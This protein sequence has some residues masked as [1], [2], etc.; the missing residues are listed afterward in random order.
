MA[1]NKLSQDRIHKGGIIF[2]WTVVL[3]LLVA[4]CGET[5]TQETFTIGVVNHVPVL[6]PAFEGFKAG[7]AEFGYVEGKNVTYIYNGVVALQ[8]VNAEIESLLTQ[9]VDMLLT[10]GNVPATVAKQAVEGTDMPIVFG[11]IMYPV[12]EGVVES[13]RHPGGNLTGVTNGQGTAKA[14]EWLV[15]IAPGAKKVYLPYN[16]DDKVSIAVLAELEKVPSQL[17]IEL[18]LGE[19]H[20]VE[21]AVAAIESLPEDIDAIYRI[22]APT[23][24]PRNNELNQAA[25]KRGLPMGASLPLS[26]SMLLTYAADFF[27]MGKQMARLADQIIKGTKPAD[28]PVETAEFFFTI[29]LQTAE[30]IGLYIP[31]EILVQAD[32]II[33]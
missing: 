23:L 24:D 25:M 21:E 8:A 13:L 17:G 28:L 16:P 1:G 12:E 31:D 29:N 26:E 30:A 9:D 15:T 18:V 33:R 2:V 5:Q 10:L 22:P 4:A 27:E 3:S 6:T 20:S 7:M 14:L 11:P 19:V 32:T